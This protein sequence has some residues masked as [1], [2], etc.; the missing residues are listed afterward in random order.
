MELIVQPLDAA[1]V[2]NQRVIVTPVIDYAT[3]DYGPIVEATPHV[4]TVIRP[5]FSVTHLK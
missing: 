1:T 3:G 4:T 5:C 2:S